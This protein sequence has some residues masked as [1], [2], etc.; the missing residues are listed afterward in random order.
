MGKHAP[1]SFEDLPDELI[2]HAVRHGVKPSALR[3]ALAKG[4]TIERIAEA[5]AKLD[6]DDRRFQN[7]KRGAQW[8]DR[9]YKRELK[10]GRASVIFGAHQ[11]SVV[12]ALYLRDQNQ[13]AS[14]GV[15]KSP[16]IAD[17]D[18]DK[19]AGDDLPPEG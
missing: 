7:S 8:R 18:Q 5:M 10:L 17:I 9:R 15:S 2:E 1:S 19:A 6:D 11:A 14:A 4:W 12:G 16:A 13:T 3:E